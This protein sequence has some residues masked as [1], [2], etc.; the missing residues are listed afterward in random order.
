MCYNM[1]TENINNKNK[2]RNA[3]KQLV[4]LIIESGCEINYLEKEGDHNN[5]TIID[6]EKNRFIINILHKMSP[7]RKYYMLMHE[8]GH[9]LLFHTNNYEELFESAKT[10]TSKVGLV[11]TIEEEIA[12]WEIGRQFCVKHN[13]PL[14]NYFFV[15]KS[16]SVM[17][18][19]D[20][21]ITVERKRKITNDVRNKSKIQ[22]KQ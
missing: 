11:Q 8:Y 9:I 19:I 18:Y 17:S 15:I 16:I 2:W 7:K 10:L 22:T 6:K 3:L 21:A 20:Y 1:I 5:Q 4:K 12:A 13:L 14:D